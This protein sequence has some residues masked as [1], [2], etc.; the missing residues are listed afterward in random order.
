MALA[1]NVYLLTKAF[2]AD[3]RFGLTSQAR[4]A[5]ASIPA[6]IAEG[7]GRATR[8]AYANFLRIAHGSLKELEMHL[9]LASRVGATSGELVEPLLVDA[10][11][12]GKMLQTLLRKLA[13]S[14]PSKPKQSYDLDTLLGQITPEN[15]PD[16]LDFGPPI[17]REIQ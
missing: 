2:P 8:P 11:V 1:E 9:M 12:L 6:N 3:E 14:A 13:A 5:A 10:D 17:G 16:P 7:H 4:R 15:L